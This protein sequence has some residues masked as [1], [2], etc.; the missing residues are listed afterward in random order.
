MCRQAEPF[1]D[2]M[3]KMGIL[4]ETGGQAAQKVNEIWDN[5][6]EWWNQPKIQKARKEWAWNYA[7]TSKHWR[8]DWIK[9]IWNL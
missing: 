6:N 3:K 4:W 2:N 8:R 7:R 5:V 9:V 1:F